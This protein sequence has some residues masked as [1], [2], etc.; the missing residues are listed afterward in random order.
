MVY[1]MCGRSGYGLAGQCA[2]SL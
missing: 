2:L 1:R